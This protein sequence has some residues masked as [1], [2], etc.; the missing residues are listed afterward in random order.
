MKRELQRVK[1]GRIGYGDVV[2]IR[3]EAHGGGPDQEDILVDL[4]G[5]RPQRQ[6]V[7]RDTLWKY[8]IVDL[9]E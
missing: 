1:D 8:V 5:P 6:W 2:F 3:A 4:G 7:H 9:K